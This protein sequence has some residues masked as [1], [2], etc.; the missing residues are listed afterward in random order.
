MITLIHGPAELLRAEARAEVAA[1]ISEDPGL[2]D[3]NTARL[4]GRTLTPAELQNACD[5]LPFLAEHR[6]VIV[7]GLLARLAG[8]PRG[9]AKAEAAAPADEEA[10]GQ[11][12]EHEAAPEALKGQAKA[13]LAYLEQVP[14]STELLL[15]EE[16]TGSGP[17]LRRVQELAR[18]GRARIV[19][20]EKPRKNDL[21]DWIRGRARL[22]RARLDAAAINDLAEFVGDELR[23]LDQELIKLA[24]Y[25]GERTVTR[26]DVRRLVAAT[27]AAN[28][29][30]LVDALGLGDA[31]AAGRL[32]QRA[33]DL[34]GEPPLRL[35]AMIARQYRL[36][37]QVKTL[38]AQ[39]ARPPEIARTLNLGE[40][41]VPRFVNQANR[42]TVARLVRA[43][44]RILAAD[45]A[46]KTG[47]LGDREAMDIL[48]AELLTE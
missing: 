33:L 31:P 18:G 13:F 16:D 32:M 23:Q 10:E 36:L 46:I 35:M 26:E 20:C 21:P 1:R 40:W 4:D 8:P 24:D 30:E 7:E 34:D 43:L 22:R 9:R 37:I 28:V 38:Q 29:F 5:T 25:A 42:H 11:P 2:A 15:L 19:L 47:K 48:L 12:A 6:L 3:L 17:G 44:E 41:M 39:G 27:R 45:E 14:E